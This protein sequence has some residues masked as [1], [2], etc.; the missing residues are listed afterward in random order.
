M[1]NQRW[2]C[3]VKLRPCDKKHEERG[4]GR[5][6]P[7]GLTAVPTSGHFLWPPSSICYQ[8]FPREKWDAQMCNYVAFLPSQITMGQNE[9]A[10]LT[11][12]FIPMQQR[13][14]LKIDLCISF[15]V[16]KKKSKQCGLLIKQREATGSHILVYTFPNCKTTH[17]N[18]PIP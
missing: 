6:V 4:C 8:H 12:L 7:I 18:C 1:Q 10:K 11:S 15:F 16:V 14:S 17:Y 9:I 13:H 3:H 5:T 2:R